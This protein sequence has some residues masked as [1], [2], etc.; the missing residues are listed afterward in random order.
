MSSNRYGPMVIIS[1]VDM[2]GFSTTIHSIDTS[3]ADPLPCLS[4]LKLIH[5]IYT[6][7]QLYP[8]YFFSFFLP[9]D[10]IFTH[11]RVHHHIIDIPL[12]VMSFVSML[13]AGVYMNRLPYHQ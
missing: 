6:M 3:I 5:K 8:V 9:K 4:N 11:N 7:Q 10:V 2:Y 12:S 13:I 1:M